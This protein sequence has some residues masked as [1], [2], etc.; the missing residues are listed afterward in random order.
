MTNNVTISSARELE[1]VLFCIDFVAK[2]LKQ[3]PDVI[4]QKLKDSG[5]LQ[6][7][8][9]ENFDILHTQGKDYLVDDII[10]L[11]QER[12]LL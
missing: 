12:Q 7:Y 10:Q 1:F 5:L 11:M 9:I 3:P 8:L 4:Y 6:N 2:H